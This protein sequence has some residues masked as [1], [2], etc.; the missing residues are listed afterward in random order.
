[1]PAG[2]RVGAM[3]DVNSD[4]PRRSRLS[5]LAPLRHRDFSLF[6]LGWGTTRFGRAIEETGAFWLVYDLTGSAAMLGVLGLARAIPAI[7][8]GPFAGAVADRVNQ[9]MILFITQSLGGL[10][11]LSAGILIATGHIEVWHLYVLVAFESTI[12]AFDGGTRLA[13]FPRLVPREL[14]SEAVTLNSTAS[15][16]AQLV[17]PVIGGIAIGLWGVAAP[18]LLNAATFLVMIVAVAAMRP[19][20]P[21]HVS[22]TTYRADMFEGL[23]H[24]ASAPVLRG[25][26]LLEIV[27]GIVQINSVIITVFGREVLDVSPEGLGGLLAAPAF[28]SVVALAGFMAFGH[29][30]RQGRFVV[31]CAMVYSIALLVF[32]SAN[33]YQLVIAVLATIGL[34]DGLMTVT[35]H[36]VMQFVSPPQMR[37]RI[38]GLMGTI[39]RGTGPVGE[40]QSGAVAALVGPRIALVIAGAVLG[41]AAIATAITN[42]EL[43]RF[44]RDDRDHGAK[45]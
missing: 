12:D 21:L 23:K 13:L 30:R 26:L 34:L 3:T 40:M 8:L 28:G 1:M 24:V 20:L 36:T 37:G 45:D 38:M 15:R 43:W 44:R 42:R 7:T 19:T 6:L 35:R 39:T 32:A 16:T 5:G 9:R 17:G 18:Y 2:V 33:D 10:A 25:L 31:L 41:A 29:A 14:L 11:S 27:V 4:R 22:D